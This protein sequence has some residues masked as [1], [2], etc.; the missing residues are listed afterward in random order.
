MLGGQPAPGEDAEGSDEDTAEAAEAGEERRGGP[1][2]RRDRDHPGR[3]G[4]EAADAAVRRREVDDRAGL[5][6]LGLPGPPVPVLH[7]RRGRGRARRS[8]HR[9]LPRPVAQYAQRAQFIVVTHQKRT[10]EAADSL[11]GVSMGSDGISKVISRRLPQDTA[12][13]RS[14]ILT[15]DRLSAVFKPGQTARTE[16]SAAA[17]ALTAANVARRWHANGRTCSSSTAPSR[18]RRERHRRAAGERRVGRFRRLRENLRKTRQALTSEIQATLFEELERRD[19]GAARGGADLRR[20]RRAHH[21]PGR[22]SSSSARQPSGEVTGGEALTA[23]L[24]ELLAEIARTGED[25]I[26]L[27]AVAH[28]DPDGRRQRHGQ[29][30]HGGQARLAPPAA[31]SDRSVVLAAADTFRAAARRAARAVGAAGRRRP[32][33]RDPR[34][35]TRARWPTTRSPSGAARAPTW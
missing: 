1:A 22:R 30:D 19:L 25:R 5:P 6:V 7:P 26:D 8:Q 13:V 10:M 27:H 18:R 3:Q 4:D 12:V 15:L 21:R 17:V 34:T 24:T 31:S 9:P 23:R 20:R 14:P 28:G 16:L 35:P 11:Y 32:S 2:R 33:S 29:D